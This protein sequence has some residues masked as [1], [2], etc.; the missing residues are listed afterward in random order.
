VKEISRERLIAALRAK[1]IR[2]L[3]AAPGA[4]SPGDLP[5]RD[6]IAGLASHS[7]PRLRR[8]LTALFLAHPE[9]AVEAPR[10]LPTVDHRAAI[11]VQSRYMAAVYLQ[12]FWRTR[13]SYYLGDYPTLPDLFSRAMGLPRPDE[14]F[15]KLGLTA[16]AEWHAQHSTPEFNWLA[17][18]QKTAEQYFGQ[19]RAEAHIH[20]HTPIG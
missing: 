11:E 20:E 18:Y 10:V 4:D 12:R 15:G 17:S 3:A 8:A 6:L 7:D 9:F 14:H 13:L 5:P 16:L 1:G 19:L 2:F